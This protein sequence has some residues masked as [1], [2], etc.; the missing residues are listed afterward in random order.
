VFVVS[1]LEGSDVPVMAKII[2]F[3]VS[4]LEVRDVSTLA[5]RYAWKDCN[6]VAM[7]SEKLENHNSYICELLIQ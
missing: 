6:M 1:T 7:F 2:V 3:V 5:L 4:T